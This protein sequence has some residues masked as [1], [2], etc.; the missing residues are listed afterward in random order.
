MGLTTTL[1]SLSLSP[2]LIRRCLVI[3]SFAAPIGALI[4]Y[5]LVLL[6]GKSSLGHD[7]TSIDRLGW[8]TG[9]SLLFSGGSFLYVATVI[10]PL[11]E[12]DQHQHH[13]EEGAH[14]EESPTLGK[15]TR[16]ALLITG[17]LLPVLLS[18]VVG[19]DEH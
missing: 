1:L 16:T 10:Q 19:G 15:Y 17:M 18:T 6:F 13:S 11:S 8:W 4:T 14:D 7:D 9:I 12:P 2:A 5:G 3:F